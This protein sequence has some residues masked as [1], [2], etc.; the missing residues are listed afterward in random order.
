MNNGTM[1]RVKLATFDPLSFTTLVLIEDVS[2]HLS[3]MY[4]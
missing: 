4:F 3:C 2:T 1:L